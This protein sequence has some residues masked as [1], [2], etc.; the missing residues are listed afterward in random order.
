MEELTWVIEDALSWLISTW[1]SEILTTVN[2]VQEV[3]NTPDL[4]LHVQNLD[5]GSKVTS[6]ISLSKISAFVFNEFKSISVSKIK[7][8]KSL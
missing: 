7:F 3:S 8:F 6:F 5:T 1:K 2:V 4:V